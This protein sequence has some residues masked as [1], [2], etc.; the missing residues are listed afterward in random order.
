MKRWT[1]DSM[2]RKICMI[3]V[4]GFLFLFIISPNVRPSNYR[5]IISVSCGYENID[6]HEVN[7]NGKNQGGL[8][9]SNSSNSWTGNQLAAYVYDYELDTAD[10]FKSLLGYNGIPVALVHIEDVPSTDF[11]SCSLILIGPDTGWGDK[12]GDEATVSKLNQSEKPILGLGEGGSAFFGKLGLDIG[13]GKGW[14]GKK[15][16][17]YVV[18]ASHPIYDAPFPITIPGDRIL[19]LYT[20]TQHVGIYVKQPSKDITL[21]GREVDDFTHYPL[22]QQTD[23]YFLWGFRGGPAAMKEV[24]KHLFVNVAY[25]LAPGE[26]TPTPSSSPSEMQTPPYSFIIYSVLLLVIVFMILYIYRISKRIKKLEEE[27]EKA[28][29]ETSRT[30][31]CPVCKNEIR[32]DWTVCPH[33]G[34]RLKWKSFN[35]KEL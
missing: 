18:D 31:V 29:A 20:T 26:P 12:W 23:K 7:A 2:G 24:G 4:S 25:Y 15:T 34:V 10:S 1:L 17:I 28:G 27:W 14:H 5:D 35:K 33:C 13:W 6:I 19:D 9:N 16:G 3:F 8:T 11:S 32:K 21:F 30:L 22:V